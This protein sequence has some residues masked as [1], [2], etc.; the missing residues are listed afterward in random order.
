MS[1]LAKADILELSVSERIQL[2]ED[3]WDSI[4]EV[5][6][7][8]QLSKEQKL[9]LDQRLDSYHNNPEQGSPWDV[10]RDRIRSSKCP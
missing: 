8:I 9:V 7:S 10:V 1:T 2:V 4:T 5:P 3:I 6:N